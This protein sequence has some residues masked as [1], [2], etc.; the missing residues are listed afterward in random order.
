MADRSLAEFR[1]ITLVKKNTILYLLLYFFIPVTNNFD[2][3]IFSIPLKRLLTPLYLTVP[4]ALTVT[5]PLR[6]VLQFHFSETD[7]LFST[8]C[9]AL[10]NFIPIF[11]SYFQM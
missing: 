2:L 3:L 8:I 1:K 9:L 10:T 6:L 5:V 7:E 11:S 4:T